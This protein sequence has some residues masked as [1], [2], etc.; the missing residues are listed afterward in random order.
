[1]WTGKT[2]GAGCSR[3]RFLRLQLRRLRCTES[4]LRV[5]ATAPRGAS[6][7]LTARDPPP[8]PGSQ[9]CGD[10]RPGRGGVVGVGRSS[11][12]SHPSAV[13]EPRWARSA[14]WDEERRA[15]AGSCRCLGGRRS[16]FVLGYLGAST[17]GSLFE[18]GVPRPLLVRR[19][20]NAPSPR[21]ATSLEV[22]MGR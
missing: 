12:A 5:L 3:A 22:A 15:Q 4:T 9:G 6:C 2:C 11:G 10:P 17:P 19:E 1:M 20:L 13:P 7:Q 18:P 8:S 14:R 16:P 21:G